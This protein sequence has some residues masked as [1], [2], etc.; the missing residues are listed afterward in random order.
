M[1][2][3]GKGPRKFRLRTGEPSPGRPS[4][5]K[6]GRK[7]EYVPP[8]LAVVIEVPALPIGNPVEIPPRG[9]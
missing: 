7:R 5:Q 4:S 9:L 1:Q 3:Y 8:P 2:P 6:R